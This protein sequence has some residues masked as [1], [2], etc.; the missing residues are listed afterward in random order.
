M[1][2]PPPL[3]PLLSTRTPSPHPRSHSTHQLR[4]DEDADFRTRSRDAVVAL[5]RGDAV[6]L[7][8]WAALCAAS[9]CAVSPQHECSVL[10]SR[11]PKLAVVCP[12]CARVLWTPGANSLLC[13]HFRSLTAQAPACA[14]APHHHHHPTTPPLPPR[15]A[16]TEFEKIY[17]LLG[18]RL[19]ERGESFYNPLLAGTVEALKEAKLADTNQGATVSA[20]WEPTRQD[21][22]KGEKGERARESE[23]AACFVSFSRAH[24][25]CRAFARLLPLPPVS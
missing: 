1:L 11:D 15:G 23:W 16:R 21:L 10:P 4:F 9:R 13:A 6:S 17:D 2:P 20:R 24:G 8:A 22:K 5:Q 3:S 12:F 19:V 18:I 7:A 14:R 25:R